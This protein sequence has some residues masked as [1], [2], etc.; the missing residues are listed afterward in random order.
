MSWLIIVND[1][2]EAFLFPFFLAY[3]L[4][5]KGKKTYIFVSCAIQFATLLICDQL[6]AY[7]LLVTGLI[8]LENMII[9]SFIRKKVSFYDLF[10]ILLYEA[11]IL[12]CNALAIYLMGLLHSNYILLLA[13]LAKG[14]LLIFT[15]FLISKKTSKI[16]N[17]DATQLSLMIPFEIIVLVGIL[18]SANLA[19][20]GKGNVLILRFILVIFI[21]LFVFFIVVTTMISRLEKERLTLEYK[22][23][24]MTYNQIKLDTIKI[25]KTEIDVIEH[26][27][28]YV[29]RRIKQCLAQEDLNE[30]NEVIEKYSHSLSHYSMVIDTKNEIFDY[31]MSLKINEMHL[32]DQDVKVMIF[33]S[34]NPFYDSLTFLNTLIL[35]LELLHDCDSLQMI[36]KEENGSF[37]KA[38]WIYKKE[39]DKEKNIREKLSHHALGKQTQYKISDLDG[40]TKIVVLFT[41]DDDDQAAQ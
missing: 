13:L 29:L 10:I 17:L 40:N 4:Q 35:M 24:A 22:M 33:I 9:T 27:L 2:L 7:Y 34:K 18:L 8:L 1:F 16:L 23:Q 11:L 37:V 12:V 3:F 32:N 25:V 20:E 30:A 26:R 38:T 5:I 19:Y 14:L 28:F 21:I 41:I 36:L 31:L 15:S 39:E 6:S